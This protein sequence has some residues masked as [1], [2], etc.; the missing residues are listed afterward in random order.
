MCLRN[1]Y[2]QLKATTWSE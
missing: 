2:I 1:P